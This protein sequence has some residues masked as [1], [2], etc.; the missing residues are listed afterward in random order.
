MKL[1]AS[2]YCKK[3]TNH[4]KYM[5]KMKNED[6]STRLKQI[7]IVG[8]LFFLI[9]GLLWLYFGKTLLEFFNK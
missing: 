4:D 6:F 2:K 7:G 5:L 9:K 3:M 1:C 8:F